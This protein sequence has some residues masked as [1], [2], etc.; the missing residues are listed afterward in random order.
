MT[1]DRYKIYLKSVND[2]LDKVSKSFC[3]A[4]WKQVTLH[5]Q[6]GTN[7]SCH[8]PRVHHIDKSAIEINPAALHNTGYKKEQRKL[9]LEN[10]RPKECDYCWRIEDSN[11][12]QF[13]DRIL[14]SADTWAYQYKEEVLKAGYINDVDPSYL[15]ISFSNVCNF[16]CSYCGPAISSQWME[17]IERYGV[18]PNNSY[19]PSVKSLIDRNLLPIPNKD[20]NPYVEAFWNYLPK[21]YKNLHTLRVTGGEPLLS[22]D[23]FKILDYIIENPNQNLILAINTNLNPPDELLEKFL[24]KVNIIVSK[25]LIKDFRIFTSGE[26]AGACAEYSRFGLDYNK[27]LKNIELCYKMIHNCQLTIMSTYNIFSLTSYTEF[28][29]DILKIK[30]LISDKRNLF[31]LD[32]PYLRSPEYLSVLN[33]DKQEKNYINDHLN[34]LESNSTYTNQ[35]GFVNHEIDKM[36]RIHQLVNSTNEY[37]LQAKKDFVNFVDEYD[38][39]RKTNFLE[40]FPQLN[41]MYERWK[42]I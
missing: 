6:N 35:L 36:K 33:L 11:E 16:K 22:K 4:K 2:D 12:H 15:E 41:E 40:T 10:I 3:I 14:K 17:E 24:H 31:I 8:H 39:R 32:I 29:S 18:Y 7:H 42:K 20:Y 19:I 37:N 28:L 30:K 26:A 23:T 1:N 13:S 21:I 27:W 5:L 25:K 9:M 38:R 34:F